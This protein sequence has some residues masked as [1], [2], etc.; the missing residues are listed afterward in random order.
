M[1]FSTLSIKNPIP[2]IVLFL[3]LTVAG[4]LAFRGSVVQMFPDID[5]PMVTVTAT[6]QGAA[7]AQLE[8]EVARKIENAIASLE[9]VKHIF[10]TIQDGAATI[11]IQF[12]LERNTAEA[13]N[14][15]RSAVGQV[16]SDLPLELLDPIINKVS[17]A[18]HPVVF[19]TASSDSSG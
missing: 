12:E 9:G 13:V 14:D 5:L 19:Y 15:V 1:N 8:T 4:L 6:L 3:L 7:P 11:T 16:R 10:T 17:T 18:G 2:A